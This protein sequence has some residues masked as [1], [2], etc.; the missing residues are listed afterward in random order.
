M[1]QM[2]NTSEQAA[3]RSEILEEAIARH[4]AAA[5]E[6]DDDAQAWADGSHP[7]YTMAR[8]SAG[9]KVR[10]AKAAKR[11]EMDRISAAMHRDIAA[12]LRALPVLSRGAR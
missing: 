1:D 9:H 12:A 7:E 10:Q 6:S 4:E 3:I 8:T 2:I 11:I 5:R